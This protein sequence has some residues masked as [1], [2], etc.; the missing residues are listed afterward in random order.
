VSIHADSCDY[1]NDEATGFKVAAAL[2]NPRPEKATR[3]T[4]CL[5]DRYARATGLPFHLNSVTPDMTSYHAFDEIDIETTAVIIEIGFL[6][7][8]R[9]LLTQEQDVVVEGITNGI[10]CYIRNED[11][12]Q[13]PQP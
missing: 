11:V 2:S 7:L 8:D 12:S 6:N 3:L 9:Q 10:L 13:D 4:S 1:V 5:R